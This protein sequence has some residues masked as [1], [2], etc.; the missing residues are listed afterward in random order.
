RG[1]NRSRYPSPRHRPLDR[2]NAP[3][4]LL[5]APRRLAH[6]RPGHSQ[7]RPQPAGPRRHARSQIDRHPRRSLAALPQLRAVVPLAEPGNPMMRP[8]AMLTLVLLAPALR[9]AAA[10]SPSNVPAQPAATVTIERVP[11]GGLQPQVA[12]APDGTLHLLYFRGEPAHGDLFYV[13]RG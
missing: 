11:D 9:P 3:D 4:L 5:G 1:S 6:R 12:L 7:G 13:H 8:I 2:R 10:Q